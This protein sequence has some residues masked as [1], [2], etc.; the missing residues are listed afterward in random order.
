M[1]NISDIPDDRRITKRDIAAMN[2]LLDTYWFAIPRKRFSENQK[3]FVDLV[4]A[5]QDLLATN[6][7]YPTVGESRAENQR[8]IEHREKLNR[9][10]FESHRVKA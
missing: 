10:Y 5:A 3:Q 2:H 1:K 8:K 9:D 6:K 7:K 4:L